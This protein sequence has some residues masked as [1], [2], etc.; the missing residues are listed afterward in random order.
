MFTKED[1][2]NAIE[3]IKAFTHPFYKNSYAKRRFYTFALV[4]YYTAL[5]A[6]TK[7]ASKCRCIISKAFGMHAI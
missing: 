7:I 2:I 4:N 3:A 1:K 6:N 5:T